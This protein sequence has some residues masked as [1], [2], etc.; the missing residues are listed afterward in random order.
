M[1]RKPSRRGARLDPAALDARVFGT[2]RV[3]AWTGDITRAGV[4]AI[5]NPLN[6]H[7]IVGNAPGTVAGAITKA[8][9]GRMQS[10]VSAAAPEPV[11]LGAVVVTEGRGAAREVRLSRGGAQHRRD[12]PVVRQGGCS[13]RL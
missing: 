3:S 5:V 8:T 4:D 2:T 6:N 11:E 13:T 1:P 12:R 10:L 9:R 7:M